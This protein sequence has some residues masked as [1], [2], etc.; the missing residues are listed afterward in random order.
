MRFIMFVFCASLWLVPP[1]RAIA[2]DWNDCSQGENNN[3]GIRGC[4]SIINSG[5]HKERESAYFNRGLAYQ[6]KGDYDR[7]IADYDQ[8]IRLNPE[9]IHAYNNR[10]VAYN[11]KGDHHRAIANLDQAIRLNPENDKA[12]NN[13]ASPTSGRAITTEPLPTMIKLS[14]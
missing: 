9:A 3:K 13:R 7:A 10:G 5:G 6:A 12:H 2:T 11:A 4:T 14:A 1:G 8:V